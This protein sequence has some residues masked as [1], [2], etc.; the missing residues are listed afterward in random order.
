MKDH[1]LLVQ[2]NCHK[3]YSVP[4]IVDRPNI[5]DNFTSYTRQHCASSCTG[6]CKGTSL[7]EKLMFWAN[8]H[9]VQHHALTS[10]LKILKTESH[11]DLPNDGRTLLNTPRYTNIYQKSG[12]DYYHYGL[13]NGILDILCQQTNLIVKNPIVINLNIDGLPIAKSSKSQLWPILAEIVLADSAITFI[14]GAY[15]GYSKVQMIVSCNIL[16][17]NKKN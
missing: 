15:H 2:E 14:V 8:E 6:T 11:D 1:N 17:L 9:K 5:T 7:K 4:N 12:G 3:K 13:K 16:L 10:L